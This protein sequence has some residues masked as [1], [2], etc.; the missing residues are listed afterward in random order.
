MS[1]IPKADVHLQIFLVGLALQL[2][3][4]FFF[5]TL[6][7]TWAWK[8]RKFEHD[9]WRKD[10]DKHWFKDWRMLLVAM[11]ISCIG[12]L[13]SKLFVCCQCLTEVRILRFDLSTV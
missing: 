13:V 1:R 11:I 10:A 3:S 6:M 9:I 8:V 12:I 5:T 4:F 2:V 7:L